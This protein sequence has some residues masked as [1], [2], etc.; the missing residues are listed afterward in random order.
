MRSLALVASLM[1]VGCG[2]A[3]QS[4]GAA[5]DDVDG[6]GG[7]AVSN[8]SASSSTG[9]GASGVGGGVGGALAGSGGTGGAASCEDP[10][11]TA[12]YVVHSLGG[13]V[14]IDGNCD[15]AVWATAPLA[16]W[17]AANNN[18]DIAYVNC[19]FLWEDAAVDRFYGCCEVADPDINADYSSL[20]DPIWEDDGIEFFLTNHQEATWQPYSFKTFVSPNGTV[21]DADWSIDG[22][23]DPGYD[24]N[25]VAVATVDGTLTTGDVDISY[26]LE[27][28]QDLG[29]NADPESVGGCAFRIND[30]DGNDASYGHWQAFGETLHVNEAAG[31][32]SCKWSCAPP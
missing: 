19:R 25:V 26:T 2:V 20:D 8:S 29:W 21:R 10:G 24:G 9:A 22:A 17:I 13:T 5:A 4:G 23:Y 31:L 27:W 15:D 6:A 11:V 32:H 3:F 16:P 12:E 18:T 14:A 1:L 30:R 28:S 7:A